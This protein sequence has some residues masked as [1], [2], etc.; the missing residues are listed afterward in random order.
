MPPANARKAGHRS[1]ARRLRGREPC[2]YPCGRDEH[3]HRPRPRSRAATRRRAAARGLLAH[4]SA[5]SIWCWS[6]SRWSS[7]RSTASCRAIST[8]MIWSRLSG[9]VERD[10]VALDEISP[11]LVAAVV[12]S[13][14]GQFC[15][16]RGVDWHEMGKVLDDNDGPSRGASTIAMQTVKNLFLW[17]SPKLCPQ[18]LRDPPRPL[19]RSRLVEAADDGDLPQR[20]R[21]GP[22]RLRRRGGGAALFQAFGQDS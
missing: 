14:D 8:L 7:S 18:G 10:W 16:H 13:E 15:A 11:Q 19:C 21:M 22:G 5:G 12:M 2:R 17:T 1:S 9:P 6:R 3:R 20:R 4:R